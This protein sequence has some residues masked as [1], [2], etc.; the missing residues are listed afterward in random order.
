MPPEGVDLPGNKPG[1]LWGYVD[2][3]DAA[4]ACRLAVEANGF[5][6]EAFNIVAA[7]SLS[8]R[9]TEEIIR[10]Y[11]PD[12]EIRAPIPGTTGGFVIEKAARLLGWMPKHSWRDHNA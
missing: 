12:T 10:E 4:A 9:P 7:D 11:L 1:N 5:G 2:V 6:F 3:R 8:A